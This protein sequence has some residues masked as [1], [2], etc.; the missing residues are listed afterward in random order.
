MCDIIGVSNP[1]TY[2]LTKG[3][4]SLL[5]NTTIKPGSCQEPE[6]LTDLKPNG[7]PRPW[8]KHKRDG[9]LLSAVYDVLADEYP[10]QAARFLERSRRI[11]DCAPF[12]EFELTPDGGKKL[13]HSSFCRCRLCPM[14]QWRRSLKLGAQVR[15]VVSHANAAKISRDGAA[16]GWLLLTVTVQNVPGEKL[17]A[18]IDHIHR[19]LNNMAKSARWKGSVKGWLRATEVTRNFNQK[20]AWYGTY[21]PHM[22]LLLCVNARYYKSKEYIKKQEWLEMWKHYAGL[23]YDPIIDIETIKTVDGQNI[24]DLPKEQR[25]ASMGKACA[26]VSKYAAKPSDYL[27]PDDLDMS[28]E[29]VRLFDLTLENR[30]MTSWGG[31]LKETAKALKLDDIE[32]GDLVHVETESEDET[33]NKL[34]DYV[35]YWWSIGAADYIKTTARRGDAPEV[36][37]QKKRQTKKQVHA[38]R[39]AAAGSGALAKAKKDAER[40]WIAW[41][42][43]P[44]EIAEIFGGGEDGE[45]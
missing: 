39:R 20:S 18:E 40:E 3:A 19:A 6:H 27:R 35:T 41:D 5:S 23:D 2:Q 1:T 15:A 4:L 34:A 43:D 38:R 36:E 9:Q 12:A 7:K 25:A 11:T 14:C 13:H 37:R 22:H 16:Y 30:R 29:T 26:E 42:A 8:K 44:E 24:N 10:E 21:H 32:T 33:A 28:A 45:T 17:S 31:V